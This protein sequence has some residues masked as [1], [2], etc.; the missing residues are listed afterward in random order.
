MQHF[1][2][3]LVMLFLC[4]LSFSNWRSAY[5]ATVKCVILFIE[6]EEDILLAARSKK[7]KQKDGEK[8]KQDSGKS[9][10]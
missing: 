4:L 8:K 3:M 10:S 5:L 2:V 7:R 1:L 9:W 6:H